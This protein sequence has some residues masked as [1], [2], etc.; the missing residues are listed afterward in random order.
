MH[1]LFIAEDTSRHLNK[2]LLSGTGAG[3]AGTSD[4]MAQTRAYQ[5]YFKTAWGSPGFYFAVK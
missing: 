2:I 4:R 3:Q 5:L 1:I